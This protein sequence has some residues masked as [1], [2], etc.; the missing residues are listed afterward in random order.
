[1]ILYHG[2]YEDAPFE[3]LPYSPGAVDFGGIFASYN[4]DVAA[5][6]GKHVFEM[7][8]PDELILGSYHLIYEIEWEKTLEAFEKI[9]GRMLSDEE[10]D[11]LWDAVIREDD[12]DEEALCA[13][14]DAAD[15]AEARWECQR[16][17]GQIA[18]H[19]G[20]QAVELEDEHGTSFLVLPGVLMRP[21][22]DNEG[23]DEHQEVDVTE[24]QKP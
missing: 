6:H 19:L 16:I 18:R 12:V 4:H 22:K 3:I 9:F 15:F 24:R 8:V 17:R 2:T 21:V 5:S 23:L 11:M 7:D 1:M 10:S 14:L 13:L 20:F